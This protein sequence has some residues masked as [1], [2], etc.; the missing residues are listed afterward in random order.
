MT[1]R[2]ICSEKHLEKEKGLVTSI[3]FF[4]DSVFTLSSAILINIQV[5]LSFPFGASPKFFID[6]GVFG[7]NQWYCYRPSVIV[8]VV[9]QKL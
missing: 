9:M 4:S 6:L 8:V 7:E 1:L 2:K 5:A 3:F